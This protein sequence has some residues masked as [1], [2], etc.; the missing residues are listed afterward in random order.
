[1]GARARVGLSIP[2]IVASVTDAIQSSR[3][4][5]PEPPPPAN[6]DAWQAVPVVS[7]IVGVPASDVI[8]DG[9]VD[10][11]VDDVP[12]VTV[13][14]QDGN[15]VQGLRVRFVVTGGGGFVDGETQY[16][17]VNGQATIEGW[18]LGPNPGDNTLIAFA[19]GI[20]SKA[21]VFRA[22]AQ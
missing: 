9:D 14:D 1:M 17:D 10:A 21:I 15:A 6:T 13:L 19:D 7:A 3:S 18:T 16:T 2:G 4:Q 20:E 12:T 5:Y 22:R 11:P 8:Q